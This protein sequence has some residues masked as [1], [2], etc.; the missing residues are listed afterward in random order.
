M[1]SSNITTESIETAVAELR[2][3]ARSS[4]DVGE[5]FR[6]NLHVLG[7]P[8]PDDIEDVDVSIYCDACDLAKRDRTAK[9]FA[10]ISLD[11]TIKNGASRH[12]AI[13]ALFVIGN[14]ATSKLE[15]NF[16]AVLYAE[17]WRFLTAEL[18][19]NALNGDVSQLMYIERPNIDIVLTEYIPR[20]F[21]GMTWAGLKAMHAGD[22][23]IKEHSDNYYGDF[24][25]F[26]FSHQATA[27]VA[28]LPETVSP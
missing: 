9:P 17:D 12:K 11:F 26:L 28:V 16:S 21:P 1:N 23:L 2:Q 10:D 25:E 4:E 14:D 22:L 6:N 15:T 20:H 19:A 3:T 27:T 24:I 5:W 7:L 18:A 8:Q 13:D